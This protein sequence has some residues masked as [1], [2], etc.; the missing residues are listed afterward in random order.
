MKGMR[1]G[2]WP[3]NT[4]PSKYHSSKVTT[5]D[6]YFDSKK[7]YK[8][9]CQLKKM[10]EDGTISGLERQ[11]KY[12]LIPSQRIDGKVVERGVRY[13]ADFKYVTADGVTVVEDVK[14]VRTPEYIIKRKLMLE[15]HGIRIKE[16]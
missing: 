12:E 8:R 15:R 4:R 13:T 7:E 9:W 14:G 10:Q 1:T 16:V 11:V 5:A 6:G 2:S 3:G